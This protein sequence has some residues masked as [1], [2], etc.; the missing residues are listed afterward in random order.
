MGTAVVPVEER[1]SVAKLTA[2]DLTGP[3]K[4]AVLC[5]ALGAEEAVKLTQSLSPE[6]A[7]EISFH[8]AQME[9]VSSSTV[10]AVFGEWMHM[11]VAVDSVAM[12]GLGYASEVLEKAFG[13]PKARMT[14]NRIQ[15]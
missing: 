15:T 13:P 12:G 3:Q 1:K 14:L 2:A 10:N 5:M 11:A 4:V 8:I 6:E 7:E 9:Q